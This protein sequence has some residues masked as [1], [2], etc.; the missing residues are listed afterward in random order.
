MAEIIISITFTFSNSQWKVKEQSIE[1]N[2]LCHTTLEHSE[3]LI[4]TAK[5]RAEFSN[6]IVK[7]PKEKTPKEE[8]FVFYDHTIIFVL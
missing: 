7:L 1:R 3:H 4:G 8:E 6:V 5:K 2:Y